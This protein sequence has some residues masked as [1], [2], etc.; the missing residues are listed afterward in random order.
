MAT[1]KVKS[2]D[3]LGAIAARY[4]TTVSALAKANNIRNVNVISVGQQ[5][6]V[7]DTYTPAPATASVP[8]QD[9]KR[10]AKGSAVQKLQLALVKLGYMKSSEYHTGP[11]IFGPK[12]EASVKKFQKAYGVEAIGVYGPKTRAALAKALSGTKPPSQPPSQPPSNPSNGMPSADKGTPM[13]AQGD[14][15]W[16]NRTLGRNYTIRSAGCA[17]TATAMAISKISGRPINPGELDAY[18][19]KNGGYYG[20]GLVWG[21]AARARG[22]SATKVGWSLGTIDAN[23]KAG[24]PMV[25]GVDYKAGSGGGANGTDHWITITAKGKDSR[26]TYYVAHDP[27]GGR[28]IKLYASGGRLYGSG[29][30]YKSTGEL[31]QFR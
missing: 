15:R 1:Y 16:G 6:K 17:M 26:G 9:L 23:L 10:G 2:G 3:T 28:E 8:S 24:R 20:D 18:L 5:L 13:Y 4:K 31:V 19:D 11:G 25:I 27:A 14:S 30:N 12:T 7:P 22:L 21:V 29:N